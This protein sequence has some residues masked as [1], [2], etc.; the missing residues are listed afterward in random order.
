MV[1]LRRHH[2]AASEHV[3][4][5][6]MVGRKIYIFAST[7]HYTLSMMPKE[8]YVK[9]QRAAKKQDNIRSERMLKIL[10]AAFVN[11]GYYSCEKVPQY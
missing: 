6:A 5:R 2:F 1:Q 8:K 9:S 4:E 7:R 11:N 10:L 3:E